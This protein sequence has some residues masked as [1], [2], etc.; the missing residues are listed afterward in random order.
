M[1]G[2]AALQETEVFSA[3]YIIFDILVWSHM[4]NL[5]HSRFPIIPI[6][7]IYSH[8]PN[9]A[10]KINIYVRVGG[11]SALTSSIISSISAGPPFP[12]FPT[13]KSGPERC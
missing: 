12:H 4:N 10:Q 13:L 9:L 2:A 5:Q 6:L 7:N 8:V 3:A 11:P 1:L